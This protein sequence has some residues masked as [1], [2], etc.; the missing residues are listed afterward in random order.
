VGQFASRPGAQTDCA[1][2]HGDGGFKPSRFEHRPP[3]TA[4]V[5]EGRHYQLTC[6]ACHREVTFAGGAHATRFKGLPASCA[7]CH[8]DVH[9][10]A[11]EGF[12]P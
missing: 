5:L 2:C 3:F 12:A 1:R 11:F 6:A 7:G 8:V 4:F 10:G 9:R